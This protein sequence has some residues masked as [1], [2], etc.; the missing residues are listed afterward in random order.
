MSQ[1]PKAL[2][3]VAAITATMAA[4]IT[5]QSAVALGLG[6]ISWCLLIPEKSPYSVKRLAGEYR[7]MAAKEAFNNMDVVG[8]GK[9]WIG[10]QAEVAMIEELTNIHDTKPWLVEVLAKTDGGAWF[11]AE[12]TVTGLKQAQV[13]KLHQITAEMA[14]EL[15]GRKPD[16][17]ERF[18]GKPE[19]A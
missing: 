11:I 1:T 7:R 9:R 14:K 10:H 5:G 3:P 19:I 6:L 17:Y 13:T 16:V 4:L 12:I 18:F 15:T 8:F 2:I